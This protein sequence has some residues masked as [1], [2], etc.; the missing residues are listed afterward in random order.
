MDFLTKFLKKIYSEQPV[1]TKIILITYETH[2][3]FGKTCL[4]SNCFL[5]GHLK[6]SNKATL[7]IQKIKILMK[8]Q[9]LDI[10]RFTLTRC[11]N[12]CFVNVD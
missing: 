7:K 1:F 12:V 4:L 3:D 5:T 6:I 11:L 8:R 2:T 9:G 10:E